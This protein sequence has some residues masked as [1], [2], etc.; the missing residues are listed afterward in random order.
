MQQP[1]Y[2]NVNAINKEHPFL[3][4]QWSLESKISYVDI[5]PTFRL[6][7]LIRQNIAIFAH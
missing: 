5:L 2:D 7:L 1:R 4:D 3:N 6:I